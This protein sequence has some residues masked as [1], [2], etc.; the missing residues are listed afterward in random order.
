MR[1]F[2][3]A[4]WAGSKDQGRGHAVVRGAPLVGGK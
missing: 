1:A 2:L 3:P 4:Y